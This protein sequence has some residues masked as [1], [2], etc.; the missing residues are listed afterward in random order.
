MRNI[1]KF[2]FLLILTFVVV[3]SCNKFKKKEPKFTIGISFHETNDRWGKDKE[4]IINQIEMLNGEVVFKDAE[5]DEKKQIEQ[6]KELILNKNIKV[7]IVVAENTETAKAIVEFAHKFDVKVIAF[8]R[9][10][11]NC[12]L[13]F[14][15]SVDVVK[16]GE[17]MV[18]YCLNL[19]PTGNYVIINGGINDE[20]SKLLNIGINNSIQKAVNMGDVKVVFDGFT[21]NWGSNEA[22]SIVDSLIKNKSKIDV[23]IACNDNLADGAIKALK[24]HGLAGKVAVTGQDA[25]IKG[26][27]N[28]INGNQLMTIYKPPHFEAGMVAV[29]ASRMAQN[30]E[31]KSNASISNGKIFVPSYIIDNIYAVDKFNIDFT[32]I[33]DR[34]YTREEIYGEK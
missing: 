22:M 20:N 3:L 31:L 21:K 1:L 9:I 14:Y 11:S 24:K 25:I 23:I 26:C 7:L 5:N 12:D 13:D 2:L 27:K 29:L 32:V 6:I 28:I 33:Y 8:D 10:I 16:I 15:V 17:M 18:D 19:Y 30:Q 4:I 34:Y